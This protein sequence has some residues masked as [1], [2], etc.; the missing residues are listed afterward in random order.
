MS[1]EW[2]EMKIFVSQHR[3]SYIYKRWNSADGVMIIKTSCFY[4]Q[5]RHKKTVWVS[6]SC[7]SVVIII[8]LKWKFALI[9]HSFVYGGD[10]AI[11]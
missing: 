2:V 5:T 4:I 8:S 6:V 10:Y 7:I 11:E 9:R 3:F 1:N